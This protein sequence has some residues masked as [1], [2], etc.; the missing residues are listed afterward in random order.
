MP[1]PIEA[2][3]GRVAEPAGATE[4]GESYRDQ[5]MFSGTR[6]CLLSTGPGRE[7]E[8]QASLSVVE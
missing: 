2:I 4:L 7:E 6:D 8:L 3:K 5:G 1:A